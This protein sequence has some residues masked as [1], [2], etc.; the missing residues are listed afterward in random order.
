MPTQP[1]AAQMAYA[2]KMMASMGSDQM[3]KLMSSKKM[4][5]MANKKFSTKAEEPSDQDSEKDGSDSSADPS[6][7]ECADQVGELTERREG[8][9]PG[10]WTRI[11]NGEDKFV[12]M[13]SALSKVIDT[14]KDDDVPENTE[15]KVNK[16]HRA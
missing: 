5:K 7:M 8:V 6:E 11:S 3:K 9:F 1:N 16:F 13:E 15:T 2:Q 10:A 14:I 12:F 4:K